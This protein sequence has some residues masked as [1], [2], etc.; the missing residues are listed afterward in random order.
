MTVA[1]SCGL[2]G[3]VLAASLSAQQFQA[4]G[5]YLRST[6]SG[7]QPRKVAVADFNG[8][9]RLDLAVVHD[10]GSRSG[11]E[12]SLASSGAIGLANRFS[13]TQVVSTSWL[14]W[15]ADSQS[16]GDLPNNEV[17]MVVADLGGS[18]LPDIAIPDAVGR[19]HVWENLTAPGSYSQVW[20]SRVELSSGTSD[21]V[22]DILAT[23]MDG[24]GRFDL[25]C[26]QKTADA[27]LVYRNQG[28][29][30]VSLSLQPTWSYAV[31]SGATRPPLSIAAHDANHDGLA[32]SILLARDGGSTGGPVLEAIGI[33][34]AGAGQRPSLSLLFAPMPIPQKPAFLKLADLNGDGVDDIVIGCSLAGVVSGVIQTNV[35][36]QLL[37]ISPS[38]LLAPLGA[39]ES[40]TTVA[41]S[42]TLGDVR[43]LALADIDTDGRIDILA[44]IQSSS[45]GFPLCAFM[46]RDDGIASNGPDFSPS[47]IGIQTGVLGS[48]PVAAHSKCYSVAVAD[49]V[50]TNG[51]VVMD[52]VV[53]GDALSVSI[54]PDIRVLENRGTLPWAKF[55][56]GC[57]GSG[58]V[59]NL[60]MVQRAIRGQAYEVDVNN[61]PPAGGLLVL[62]Y[63]GSNVTFPGLGALPISGS[64]L[65]APGCRLLVSFDVN[66]VYF[67]MPNQGVQRHTNAI[68][69]SQALLGLVFFNQAVVWDAAANA[70]G[71]TSSDACQVRVL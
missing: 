18:S 68:P 15:G 69:N 24:D 40:L 4:Y 25:L 50:E 71:I 16:A 29:T 53:S 5:P 13:L 22:T 43:S 42:S 49:M 35:V 8:D 65:G 3:L 32:D 1:S 48:S 63:G 56:R 11:V 36:A 46:N 61:L 30:G 6:T 2:M 9:G 21:D 57:A 64:G 10:D 54:T 70:L 23:D 33:Q 34:R 14:Q 38:G 62:A 31:A 26:Y 47:A 37:S 19:I 67:V 41:A 44:V 52:L 55:G 7:I 39:Q 51:P 59:P 17:M 45:T 28:G 66:Y 20:G 27:L 12:I 58:G 60:G